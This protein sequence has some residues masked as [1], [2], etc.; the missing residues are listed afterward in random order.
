[1]GVMHQVF[2]LWIRPRVT[3]RDKYAFGVG[4]GRVV[5]PS[6]GPRQCGVSTLGF[7][8]SRLFQLL[9]GSGF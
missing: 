7:S 4:I 6:A 3:I 1:M 9:E 2:W 5:N 8:G